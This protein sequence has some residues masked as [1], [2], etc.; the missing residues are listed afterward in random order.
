VLKRAQKLVTIV[1]AAVII[2]CPVSVSA[3]ETDQFSNRS[4][5]V[6]DS[7]DVLN[8]EVN[9]TL[10]DIVTNWHKGHDEMAMVNAIYRRIGG[11]HWVD[12]LERWAMKSAEVGKL[13]TPRYDSVYSGL[14]IWSVRVTFFFGIGKTIRVNDELIGSDKI[15]HFLSQGRKF[16]R[17]YIRYGSEERAAKRSAL[18]ERAIFGSLTTGAYSN[19]D[20]V[21]NF[22]GYRFYR[23][24]FED[25]VVPGKPAILRWD[26]DGWIIQRPFEWTDFVNEYWDEALNVSHYDGLLYKHMRKRLVTFCPQYWENPAIY[27][28]D[29]QSE[30]ELQG[31]YAHLELRDTRELRLDALCAAEAPRPQAE[32]L[33]TSTYP[34]QARRRSRHGPTRSF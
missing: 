26:G 23:S 3:Y 34:R 2:A 22:E 30:Q 19:A 25:D 31:R 16:Y 33:T 21:A 20:L 18:T 13:S 1:V 9:N 12:K 4:E 24:L 15:G 5:P 29:S 6:E 32:E 11:L 27:G 8:Q 7:T 17:R 14:P 10:N 28:L